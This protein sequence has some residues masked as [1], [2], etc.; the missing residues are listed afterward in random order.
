MNGY[1]F[2]I[3]RLQRRRRQL[4]LGWA[5]TTRP[6]I[7]FI[8]LPTTRIRVRVAGR[9]NRTIVFACDMPNVVDNYDDVI[10]LLENDYRIVVF[11]QPGFG[12]SH[13]KAGFDFTRQ[14][15][16]DA[17]AG[18]LRELAIGPY[19]L[20]FPCVSN[21]YALSV[22]KQ[23]P[24]LVEK[25]VLMQASD[26]SRQCEWAGTVIGRFVLVTMGLP[27]LGTQMTATPYL[28]QATWAAVEPWFARRTH[29]HVIYKSSERP[30]LFARLSKP[31]YEAYEHGACHCFASA[32]QH[33]F[34]DS[35]SEIPVVDQPALILWATGD[36]SHHVSN[37][38]GL[39]NYAPHARWQ[40]IA[41][42]GHHLDL[43]NPKAVTG[44]IRRFLD[45]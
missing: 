4:D 1:D 45:P 7:R 9:G 30:E 19:I 44:A 38:R 31:L 18:M 27:V 43:E 15:Y 12:F 41:D 34:C 5:A 32:F 24:D 22:A 33:F 17:L 2:D 42:T 40:E 23:H 29:H 28:G 20:A 14:A 25:L 21:F 16:A 10:R 6:G 39:M 35:E 36:R 8:D 37:S 26:W 13:P 11:E 3:W